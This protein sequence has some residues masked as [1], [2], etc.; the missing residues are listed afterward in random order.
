MVKKWLCSHA[1]WLHAVSVD[2]IFR[3]LAVI[4]L[5][6]GMAGI[7]AGPQKVSVNKGSEGDWALYSQH[8]SIRKC[9]DQVQ[10]YL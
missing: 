4:Y 2:I 3:L 5:C 9:P 6:C 10:V 1:L 7:P 8:R